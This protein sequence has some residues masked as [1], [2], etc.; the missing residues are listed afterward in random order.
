MQ[1]KSGYVYAF[2]NPSHKLVKLGRTINIQDR[3]NALSSDTGVP[4]PYEC[5]RSVK[6]K[7]MFAV[8]KE[9]HKIINQFE[10]PQDACD[11]IVKIINRTNTNHDNNS[12]ILIKFPNLFM[13]G[14]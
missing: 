10:N 1:D 6:V 4:T 8:E 3:L 13:G 9:L 11:R 7:D 12:L 2:T 14:N 5:Y